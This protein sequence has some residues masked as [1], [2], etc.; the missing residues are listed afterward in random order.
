MTP[1]RLWVVRSLLQ[2]TRRLG[3][4]WECGVYKGGTARF[5][6]DTLERLGDTTTLVRLFDTFAGMPESD[7]ARDLHGPG[8]FADTSASAVAERVGR[9]ER[10]CIHAGWIPTTFAG[11]ESTTIGFAHVDTDIYRSVRDCAEFVWPRL[12]IGGAVV[13][14]DYGF[15][16]CPGAR[17]AVD[18]FFVAEGT[19]VPLALHTGQ[20][21]VFKGP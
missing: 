1:D 8:D 15:P 7:P 13:F 21:V 18:E 5:L 2:Q 6:V 17:E 16:T 11:L 4:V 3:E 19:A 12:A 14:D 10:V 20:A 9:P